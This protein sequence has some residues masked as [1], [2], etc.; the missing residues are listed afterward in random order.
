M[1][2]PYY[3][4]DASKLTLAELWRSCN[5]VLEFFIAVLCKLIGVNVA[6]AF[7]MAR[8]DRLVRIA[9]GAVPPFAHSRMTPLVEEAE[10]L[11]M[12]SGF[13]FTIPA[14][15]AVEGYSRPLH[16]GDGQISMA[17]DCVRLSVNAVI[18]EK[19]TFYFLTMLQDGRYLVTSGSK[20][21]ENGPPNHQREYLRGRPMAEVLQR[22]RERLAEQTVVLQPVMDDNQLERLMFQYEREVIDYQIQRRVFTPITEVEVERLRSLPRAAPTAVP[23]NVG[24]QPKPVLHWLEWACWLTLLFG[25]YL[26]A[27]RDANQA[28][29]VF[30]LALV[31]TGLLCVIAFQIA[32]LVRARG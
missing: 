24:R 13:Y 29:F 2:Y 9:P 3:Q 6:P 28:Q 30:R 20:R 26:F 16:S 25:I 10:K 14:V 15:G 11:G 17:I 21:E 23:E 18:N 27:K 19:A 7:G 22:H 1:Q 32:R 12:K 4:F 8:T 5:N 31:S